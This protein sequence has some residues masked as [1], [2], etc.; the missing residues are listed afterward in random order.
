MLVSTALASLWYFVFHPGGMTAHLGAK[1]NV[2]IEFYGRIVDQEGAEVSD[3]V[4]HYRVLGIHAFPSSIIGKDLHKKGQTTS[5]ADGTFVIRGETGTSMSINEIG[6]TGYRQPEHLHGTFGYAGNPDPFKPNRNEPVTFTLIEEGK[7]TALVNF[8]RRLMFS[9]DGKPRH[10]D[11]VTGLP[12]SEGIIEIVPKRARFT[13]NNQF[14]FDWSLSVRIVGGGIVWVKE[15]RGCVAPETGYV[16]ALT[17]GN[18]KD[19][20]HLGNSSH[21]TLYAK[22]SSGQFVRLLLT[23]Y[24]AHE[25]GSLGAVIKGFVNPNAGS[26]VLEFIPSL[27]LGGE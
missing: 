3:A 11:I 18:G 27:H 2:P 1:L 17:F 22:L 15:Q 14:D 13:P 25:D 20:V 6:R 21:V 23:I 9:W 16:P 12:S 8:D 4:V 26:R 10:Y 24:Q 5:R 19:D 7:V